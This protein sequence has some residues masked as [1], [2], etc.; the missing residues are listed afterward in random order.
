VHEAEKLSLEQI[1]V[2]LKASQGEL[3]G[4]SV[5]EVGRQWRNFGCDGLESRTVGGDP[6]ENP[7]T[8]TRTG[9]LGKMADILG[10]KKEILVE[11]IE[12]VAP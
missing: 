4:R 6:D 3:G 1:E 11:V 5:A 10:V 9:I 12:V 2:F 8:L 7:F